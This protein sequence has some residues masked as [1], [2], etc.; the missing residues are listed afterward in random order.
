MNLRQKNLIMN[1]VMLVSLL[2]VFISGILVKFMPGMWLG[3]THGVSGLILVICALIH[4]IT[5]GM[6]K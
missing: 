4:C 5:H 6:F 1:W 2:T 3:I